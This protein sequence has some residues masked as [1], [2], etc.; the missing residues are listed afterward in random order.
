MISI[1]GEIQWLSKK[2]HG[3]LYIIMFNFVCCDFTEYSH[4]PNFKHTWSILLLASSRSTKE[5]YSLSM[6]RRYQSWKRDQAVYLNW[7]MCMV[8]VVL[9]TLL[10]ENWSHPLGAYSSRSGVNES[11]VAWVWVESSS[12]KNKS[13]LR[14]LQNLFLDFVCRELVKSGSILKMR[15]T[16]PCSRIG[17][18]TTVK[19]VPVCTVRTGLRKK[20]IE[21]PLVH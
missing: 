3:P 16:H 9:G 2:H 18:A 1:V 14:L 20:E 12:K 5:A 11:T 21:A 6:H 4:F 13:T 15:D 19:E 8:W 10:W 17:R 7:V